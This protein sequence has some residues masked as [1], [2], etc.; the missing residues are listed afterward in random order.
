MVGG[1]VE[2]YVPLNTGYVPSLHELRENLI[3]DCMQDP[4]IS[5]RSEDQETENRNREQKQWHAISLTVVYE[6]ASILY[7]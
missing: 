6:G 3:R 1:V 4:K 5:E 7:N 2:G